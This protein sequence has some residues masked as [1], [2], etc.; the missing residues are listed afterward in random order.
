MFNGYY[1]LQKAFSLSGYQCHMKIN[2]SIVSSIDWFN[3]SQA[4]A[5]I[6]IFNRFCLNSEQRFRLHVQSSVRLFQS[7]LNLGFSCFAL[8]RR[9]IF[10]WPPQ[11]RKILKITDHKQANSAVCQ[12]RS[13]PAN[14]WFSLCKLFFSGNIVRRYVWRFLDFL[15]RNDLWTEFK[16]KFGE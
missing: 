9:S 6:K 10:F 11:I 1:F 4:N 5:K 2:I 15:T 14:V 3:S 7:R 8:K 12:A 13:S 16:W